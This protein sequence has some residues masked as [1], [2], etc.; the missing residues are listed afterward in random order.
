MTALA[1]NQA[2]VGLQKNLNVIYLDNNEC[3]CFHHTLDRLQ[4]VK[5]LD[6]NKNF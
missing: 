1:L 5:K 6:G 2:K 3:F 4:K